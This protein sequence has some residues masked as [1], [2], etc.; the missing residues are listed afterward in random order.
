[1]MKRL[2]K[3]FPKGIE[4]K[5]VYDTTLFVD[6]SIEEVIKT[7]IEAMFLVFMVVYVF[8]Q[9]FRSTLI[10][11]IT[12][13]VSLVGTFAVMMALG[14][15]INTLTLFGVVL[16]IGLVVD[17]AI[18]VVENVSR[19]IEEKGMG[20][21]E[22]AI[23]G[24]REVVGPII[25][26]TLVLMAVFVPVAFMPGTT[27]QLY[28]QFA[29]TIAISVGISAINALTLSPALCALLLG[30][31]KKHG[32]FFRKFNQTFNWCTNV[33]VGWVKG[34]I[35]LWVIVALVFVG[36]LG[37]TYYLFHVVP[38]GFVPD[39]DQGYFYV[40]PIG[41]E[42]SSLERTEKVANKIEKIL[43]KTPGVADVLTIG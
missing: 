25:A 14:F 7:L 29:L 16:A 31:E 3:R 37:V 6:Q 26:T 38:T 1:V 10:P 36:L 43:R 24:M 40:F 15:S 20:S 18:V 5:I 12:I 4:Y 42:G 11:A 22:A 21:M 34:L 19:L 23:E 9:N 13:P 41:P 17:D 35:K 39:E 30:P 28:K 27:G 8:L 2:S 33:Y 32:W